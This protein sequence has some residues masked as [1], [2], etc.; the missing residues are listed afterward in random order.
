[1]ASNRRI[2]DRRAPERRRKNRRGRTA[3]D[4]GASWQAS[5]DILGYAIE[6]SDGALGR[7]EALCIEEESSA[8]T[9]IVIRSS[10]RAGGRRIFVP[11]SAV[12]HI[13]PD[14]RK[15]YLSSTRDELRRGSEA[16]RRARKQ[17]R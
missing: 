3:G 12:A 5:C 1:V 17:P 14:E 11:L 2:Q 16:E 4:R 13:D 6:A 9:Q 10:R 8:I 7:V 15:L